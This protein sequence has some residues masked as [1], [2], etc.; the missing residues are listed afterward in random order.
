MLSDLCHDFDS[1]TLSTS[2]FCT[3]AVTI[4]S[5][6]S[7]I[8]DTGTAAATASVHRQRDAS[9]SVSNESRS[10]SHCNAASIS[11]RTVQASNTEAVGTGC[12]VDLNTT[13]DADAYG[14]WQPFADKL[15]A[16]S[17]SEAVYGDLRDVWY[18]SG[19]VDWNQQASSD[20]GV[21]SSVS[22]AAAVQPTLNIL[23]TSPSDMAVWTKDDVSV[24]LQLAVTSAR[25]GIGCSIQS[26]IT[27]TPSQS[28]LET[29]D[30][31]DGH[32]VRARSEPP[33]LSQ[34]MTAASIEHQNSSL[35][36]VF[37]RFDD[38]AM[39]SSSSSAVCA[40]VSGTDADVAVSDHTN[41][42]D[43]LPANLQVIQQFYQF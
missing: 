20:S 9:S 30:L 34:V 38:E 14:K 6:S 35:D 16:S 10:S 1:D 11:P 26:D 23:D 33:E 36:A 31:I 29:D 28:L 8:C 42:A 40:T 25:S 7:E 18:G 21:D 41:S 15:N 13:D 4:D 27:T 43:L 22:S 3:R 17:G 37:G 39:T 19:T 5:V 2:A 32:S 12:L 24:N